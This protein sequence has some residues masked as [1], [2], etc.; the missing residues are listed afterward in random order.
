MKKFVAELIRPPGTGT[1]TYLNVPFAVE[2]EFGVRTRVPVKGTI[3]GVPFR[4]SLM[5]QG[6]GLHI[7]VVPG[8]IRDR[9]GVQSGD[10]VEVEL[11]RDD[12]VRT[13]EVPDDMAAALA[14]QA[15]ANE[16]FT[17]MSYSRQK[18][19]VVWIEAAKRAVTRASRIAKAMELLAQGKPLK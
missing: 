8:D 6:G 2:E 16:A 10:S 7:L 18:E 11:E 1:W 15:E 5:P 3:G 12:E 13:V 17:R 9:L 4:S 19:Y 14:K